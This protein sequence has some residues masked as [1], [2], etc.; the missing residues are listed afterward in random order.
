MTSLTIVRVIQ[1]CVEYGASNQRDHSAYVE[2]GGGRSY[3]HGETFYCFSSVFGDIGHSA[4]GIS[5]C[6]NVVSSR[7]MQ[8]S[9]KLLH[10]HD[11][12][13]RLCL[14]STNTGAPKRRSSHR[15]D[16]KKAEFLFR[17]F[18]QPRS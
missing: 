10:E 6:S 18:H 15:N 14:C 1:I 3:Q 16:Y 9:T 5:G 8:V 2:L 13:Y 11:C 4:A 7:V 17:E 12:A